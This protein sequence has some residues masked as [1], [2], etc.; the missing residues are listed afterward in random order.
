MSV[1]F[2]G[3]RRERRIAPLG[4]LSLI[5]ALPALAQ[6]GGRSAPSDSHLPPP[7][8]LE[9]PEQTEAPGGGRWGRYGPVIA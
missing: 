5:A 6:E 1:K 8:R 2:V 9:K 4:L 7:R 3:S